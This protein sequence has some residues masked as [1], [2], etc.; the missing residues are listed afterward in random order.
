MTITIN[1]KVLAEFEAASLAKGAHGPQFKGEACA[2]EW[3]SR[4][5]DEGFTDAP[6]CAS[7]VLAR[8]IIRLNDRWDDEKRQT[9]KPYLIRTIGTAGDGKDRTRERIAL[10]YVIDLIVPWLRLA[11]LDAEADRLEAGGDEAAVRAAMWA[12]RDAAWALRAKR[13]EL[14]RMKVREEMAKRP[15][16]VAVAVADAVAVAVAVADAVADA[17]AVAV[18]AAAAV[19]AAVAVADAAAAAV[20]VAAAAAA[21]DAAAA[22]AAVAAAVAAADEGP[23]E[24]YSDRWYRIR[25]AAYDAAKAHYAANPLPI[26]QEVADLAAHQNEA[27]LALL[28]KLIDANE[29]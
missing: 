28:D 19:A 7:P 20:A 10:R 17:A 9:L 6:E 22:A 18:A 11:G 27:A 5:A 13:Y 29:D 1:P 26:A 8:Y 16:A 3:V 2:L 12:A 25:G 14:I 21:A 23:I 4:L 24:L 15:V